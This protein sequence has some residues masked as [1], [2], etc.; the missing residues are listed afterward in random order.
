MQKAAKRRSVRFRKCH[1]S[2][3]VLLQPPL[4]TNYLAKGS[5]THRHFII[6]LMLITVRS[7]TTTQ[8]LHS[9]KF[10]LVDKAVHSSAWLLSIV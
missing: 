5:S 7:F 4:T 10:T 2:H 6:K 8:C 9:Y 3:S 1:F